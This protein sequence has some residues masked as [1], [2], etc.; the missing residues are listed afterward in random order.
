MQMTGR[1]QVSVPKAASVTIT[2]GTADN[3]VTMFATGDAVLAGDIAA[4]S[5]TSDIG[6]GANVSEAAG[7]SNTDVVIVGYGTDNEE[8]L[9][10]SGHTP[11]VGSAVL[12]VRGPILK[13]HKKNERVVVKPTY[14]IVPGTIVVSDN[15]VAD[16]VVDGTGSTIGTLTGGNINTSLSFVD[17]STGS[18]RLK[19]N[20]APATSGPMTVKCDVISEVADV[21]DLTGN[22]FQKNWQAH[23]LNRQSVPDLLQ[24]SNLGTKKVGCFVEVSRN[25][26]KSFTMKGL[27]GVAAQLGQYGRARIAVPTGQ[28]SVLDVVRF[29]GGILSAEGLGLD[30]TEPNERQ[31]RTGCIEIDTS[32]QINDNGQ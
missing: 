31:Q 24:C 30:E 10:V 8:Q 20:T 23:N 5:S 22:A 25:G 9:T 26:G 21:N 1:H 13:A 32:A 27:T 28:A 11:A 7:F 17:Y 6:L 18:I 19:Y 4:N 3:S 2:V 29:R 16:G 12:T 14:A 15:G